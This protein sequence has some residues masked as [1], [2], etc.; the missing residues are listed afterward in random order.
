MGIDTGEG[1]L[2]RTGQE[3]GHTYLCNGRNSEI[4]AI[5]TDSAKDVIHMRY[6][7]PDD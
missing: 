2:N 4:P 7:L 1:K 5:P 6:Q 3:I